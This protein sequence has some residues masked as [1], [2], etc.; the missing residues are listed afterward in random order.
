[1]NMIEIKKVQKS[2]SDKLLFSCDEVEIADQSVIAVIGESG[3]GKTTLLNMISLIDNQYEGTISIDGFCHK[4]LKNKKR[5]EMRNNLFSFVF[6]HPYLIDYLSVMD[7]ICFST[8]VNKEPID[9]AK[10]DTYIHLAGLEN[11]LNDKVSYLSEG[12]KQRIAIIRALA[13]DRKYI[14]CD[15]PTA[16]LDPDNA[17]II[18]KLL[19]EISLKYHKTILVALHDHSLLS[20]FDRVFEI[21]G[22]QLYALP[23]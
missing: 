11:L 22:K 14:V 3:C 12:E 15:E 10:L 18:I 1:M 19:K 2:F 21:K 4:Q 20:Y 13:Y 6:S 16:H 23:E 17:V 7:N 9:R 5:E 8:I